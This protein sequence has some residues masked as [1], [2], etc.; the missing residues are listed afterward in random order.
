MKEH[1]IY[2]VYWVLSHFH[3]MKIEP[4]LSEYFGLVEKCPSEK[5]AWT[6]YCIT[7][8]FQFLG[9]LCLN[10]LHKLMSDENQEDVLDIC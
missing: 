1:E 3:I 8:W 5:L 7:N 6:S 10:K 2:I 9:Y 4:H